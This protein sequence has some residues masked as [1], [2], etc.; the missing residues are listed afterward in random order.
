MPLSEVLEIDAKSTCPTISQLLEVSLSDW[1]E[2]ILA[3]MFLSG[4]ASGLPA[5][6]ADSQVAIRV[7]LKALAQIPDAWA[8]AACEQ[9]LK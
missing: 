7:A 6:E 1:Q 4:D 9:V 2:C 3:A 5:F 8:Q